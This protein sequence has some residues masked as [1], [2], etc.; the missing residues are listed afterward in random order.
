[1]DPN[2]PFVYNEEIVIKII[3]D[4]RVVQESTYGETSQ[5]H[6]I[7]SPDHYITNFKTDKR[8]REYNIEILNQDIIIS[9]F[10]TQTTKKIT[11]SLEAYARDTLLNTTFVLFIES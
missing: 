5:D 9:S 11:P 1:V 2:T 6:R 10:S 3:S 7:E 8:T 4:G